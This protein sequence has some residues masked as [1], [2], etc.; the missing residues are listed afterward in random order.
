[1]ADIIPAFIGLGGVIL[2][3]VLS[4]G[5]SYIRRRREQQQL[6]QAI[7]TLIR[8][9]IDQNLAWLSEV[10]QRLDK[11]EQDV[12][13][14]QMF[15]L[16]ISMPMPIWSHQ[17]WESQLV[18]VPSALS[19]EMISKVHEFHGDLDNIS[20]LVLGIRDN[21]KQV[22]YQVELANQCVD[23]IKNL[24]RKGNPIID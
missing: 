1:M 5:A 2:G 13:R 10:A 11:E 8:I 22:T 12:N 21:P 19:T 14:R 9:E 23:L 18:S 15:S 7:K 16:L 17:L 4:E 6:T 3:F 20:K 24:I